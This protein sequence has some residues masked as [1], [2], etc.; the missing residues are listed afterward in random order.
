MAEPEDFVFS[1]PDGGRLKRKLRRALMH[2][3]KRCGF[4]DVT[5][6]HSLR[7]TFASH[8]VMSGVDLELAGQLRERLLVPQGRQGHL[9]LERRPER[10]P[11]PAHRFASL[12]PP[13]FGRRIHL[14][15]A[16]RFWGVLYFP[17]GVMPTTTVG[18]W[19]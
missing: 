2:V 14:N 9:R 10:P 15:R 16:P 19:Q 5:K 8:L 11:S 3:T 18:C 12:K 1:G 13:R 17:D 4:P 7:H 6:L